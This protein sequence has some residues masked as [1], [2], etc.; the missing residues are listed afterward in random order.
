MKLLK[1]KFFIIVIAIAIVLCVI[2]TVLAAMGRTDLL[3]SGLN[4]CAT[5][6]RAVFNW[7]GDGVSGFF[8]YF[9]GVDRLIKE[10]EE[11]RAE[12]DEYR[13][14]LARAELAEGENEWLRDQLGFVNA[15]SEYIMTDARVTGRSSNSYS[16]TYTVN[17]GSESGIAVNMAVVTPSGVVG[18]V[19]EVGLGWSRVVALTDP[20]SAVGV[21]TSSGVYGT[22]EGSLKYRSDGYCVM[23]STATLSKGTLL[24]SSGYGNIFPEG[25][26]VGKIIS[27]EQDEYSHTVT[28]IVEPTVD[29]NSIS[30]VLVV[31][32]KKVSVDEQK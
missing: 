7:V 19:S 18:Y 12:L 5:P 20:T 15:H 22:V 4:L 16:V 27:S 11:L 14:A 28:Y 8:E 21:Y 9:S 30:Y 17:R 29:F 13:D 1:N 3:R 24:M 31:T 10:K 32:G 6:F 23:N 2:P 26:A 25:L